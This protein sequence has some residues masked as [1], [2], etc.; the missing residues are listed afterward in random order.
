L[1]V[2]EGDTLVTNEVDQPSAVVTRKFTE[3]SMIMV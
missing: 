3:D 2:L 1:T